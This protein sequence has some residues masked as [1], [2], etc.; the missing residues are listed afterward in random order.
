MTRFT[1][2]DHNDKG[3]LSQASYRHHPVHPN[4]RKGR[5]GS[6]TSESAARSLSALQGRAVGS[7]AELVSIS[8]TDLPDV[9]AVS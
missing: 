1:S 5:V 6:C 3:T 7:D 4:K 8:P 2:A 9:P